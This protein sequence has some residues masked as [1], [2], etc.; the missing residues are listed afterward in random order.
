MDSIRIYLEAERETERSV[1]FHP[2]GSLRL[3]TTR[4]ELDACRRLAPMFDDLGVEYRVVDPAA[5]AELHPLL[6]TAG[7]VRGGPYPH[8]RPPRR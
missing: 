5:T 8:R 1:G 3:A 4:E 6:V 7:P 2:A